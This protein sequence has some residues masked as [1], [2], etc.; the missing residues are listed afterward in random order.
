MIYML[1]YVFTTQVKSPSVTMYPPFT[2][3]YLPA[4]YMLLEDRN[5]VFFFGVF[6]DSMT[7]WIKKFTFQI[8]VLSRHLKSLLKIKLTSSSI[9]L[10]L[11][12]Y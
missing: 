7:Y 1:Y 5:L 10:P 11:W 2:L 9:V 8:N 12:S 4:P 3:F 6:L